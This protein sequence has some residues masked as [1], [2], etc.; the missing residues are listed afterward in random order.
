MNWRKELIL[1]I[2]Y[3]EWK[4]LTTGTRSV[5][6]IFHLVFRLINSTY[7][8]LFTYLYL[9]LIFSAPVY[10]YK[11]AVSFPGLFLRGYHILI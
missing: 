11:C 2:E 3:N 5:I 1:L 10:T 6:H 8:C 7:I 9:F 4:M